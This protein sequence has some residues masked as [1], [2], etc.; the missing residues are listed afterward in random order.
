LFALPT[1]ALK[2]FAGK[3]GNG[4]ATNYLRAKSEF[5]TCL[6]EARDQADI[7]EFVNARG[8]L[9][10]ALLLHFNDAQA[11][12]SLKS[13]IARQTKYDQWIAAIQ[14]FMAIRKYADVVRACK[15]ARAFA[16]KA[17]QFDEWQ[18]RAG[19]LA[20][21][22][23]DFK[24]GHYAVAERK[25]DAIWQANPLDDSAKELRD[26][27]ARCDANWVLFDRSKQRDALESVLKENPADNRAKEQLKLVLDQA[28]AYVDYLKKAQLHTEHGDYAAAATELER[29][30]AIHSDSET[31]SRLEEAKTLK[32]LHDKADL[33]F[34]QQDWT[35]AETEYGELFR[36]NP[37]DT[38]AENRLRECLRAAASR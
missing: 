25:F 15:N 6:Q 38:L 4:R 22:M 3:L 32:A 30:L 19:Q 9:T 35:A 1:D 10:N 31:R 21:A 17:A 8:W 20:E 7:G 33:F 27:S 2:R 37:K 16:P 13:I 24:A 11:E 5:A 14:Y 29:A 23:E 18:N 34:T 28:V 36:R 26:K 12:R